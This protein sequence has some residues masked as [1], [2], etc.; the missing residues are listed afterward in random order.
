MFD[1]VF[2]RENPRDVSLARGFQQ[3]RV[4]VFARVLEATECARLVADIAV[5]R[6]E[7]VPEER[8]IAKFT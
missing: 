7:L 1:V 3:E 5:T 6:C 2:F 4:I 8:K